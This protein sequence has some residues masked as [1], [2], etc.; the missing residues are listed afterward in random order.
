MS[1]EQVRIVGSVKWFNNKAGYGFITVVEDVEQKGED[2]FVHFSSIRVADAQY[3]YLVPGE[4]VE[5]VLE[6][7]EAGD[8]KYHAGDIT[9]IKGGP[10]MCET[11][12]TLSEAQAARNQDEA[13]APR[14]S[15]RAPVDQEQV[16][17]PRGPK[18]AASSEPQSDDAGFVKV[19]R[20]NSG[21]RP[22]PR[23]SV[24]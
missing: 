17:N 20:K 18:R 15:R 1:V 7:S 11:R 16:V 10:I 24:K 4:Y 23:P 12:R 8:H 13:A 6:T 9:G 14:T 2:I 21:R 22:A 5:F 3:K 19:Q